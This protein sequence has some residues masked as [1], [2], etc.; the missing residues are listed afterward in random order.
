MWY[1]IVSIPDPCSLTYFYFGHGQFAYKTNNSMVANILPT[2]PTP[3]PWGGS[4][5]QDSIFQTWAYAYQLKGKGKTTHLDPGGQNV[6]IKLF[7]LHNNLKG[8]E[9]RAPCKHKFSPYTH[10]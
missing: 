1:L 7:M 4:I 10:P 2:D 3:H 9:H 6:K 5:G 8:M